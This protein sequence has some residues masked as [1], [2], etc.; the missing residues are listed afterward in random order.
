MS[1][2]TFWIVIDNNLPT[3]IT[4][5]HPTWES[6]DREAKRLAQ[7]SPGTEFVIMESKIGYVVNNL[8][9]IEYTDVPF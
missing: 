2:L 4:Y 5:R 8:E 1:N 6:A 7:N 3:R 9:T